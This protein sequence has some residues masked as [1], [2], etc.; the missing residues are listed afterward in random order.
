MGMLI[1]D[2]VSLITLL[3]VG[4]I[5]LVF[6]YI[7][8][9]SVESPTPEQAKKP[10]HFRRWFFA[11][12]VAFICFITG[13]TL[14]PFPIASQ[15]AQAEEA[16]VVKAVGRQWSW[17]LSRNQVEAGTPVEFQ[18]TSSD[19]NHGFAIY[20]ANNRIVTQTQAMPGFTNR[21][22]YTFAEPGKYRV[23]CLEYCGLVHHQMVTEFEVVTAKEA[24]HE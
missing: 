5:S 1:Q 13:A 22:V 12:L 15:Q 20:A 19:V 10:S 17:E 7:I 8:A 21:L 3:G 6:V 4:F 9:R 2:E 16:Q 23:L 14:M 24:R 18:V 11:G